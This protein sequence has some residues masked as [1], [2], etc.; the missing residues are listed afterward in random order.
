MTDTIQHLGRPSDREDPRVLGE[1]I[2][3]AAALVADPQ[4]P[5]VD[6]EWL[7]ESQRQPQALAEAL[8]AW[9]G[10]SGVPCKSVPGE[11][12]DLY[13]DWVVRHLRR[14]RTAFRWYDHLHER[15]DGWSSLSYDELDQR[16]AVR[17]AT[18]TSQGVV[19]GAV[20]CVMLPF[21]VEAVVSLL[22]ALRVGACVSL[23][24][25][26]GPAYVARRL[27]ALAPQHVASEPFYAPWL[28]AQAKLLLPPDGLEAIVGAVSH[29]YA[30]TD[31]C[32]LLFSPL[33]RPPELPVPLPASQAQLGAL[34]DGTLTLALRAGDCLAA[35]GLHREQHQP[36]L[37]FASLAAGAAF[38]HVPAD[39]ARRDPTLLD[40]FGLRTLGLDVATCEAILR[41]RGGPAH[42]WQHVFRNPEEPT[43]WQ[44]WRELVETR[45]LEETAMSNVVIEAASGGALLSSPRRTGKQQLAALMDVLPAAGQPWALLDFTR[46]GQ[47]SVADAGVFAPLGGEPGKEAPVEP[48]HIALGRRRDA[49]LYGGTIEP[50][51][52]GRVYPAEEV[53]AALEDC[54]F[55]HGASVVGVPAGGATL[56]WRFVLLGF[57]GHE[58]EARFAA[59][60]QARCDELQRM[61]ATRLGEALRPDA[62][63]LFPLLPRAPAG[64][65]DH[66]WCQLQYTSGTLFAKARTPVFRRITELRQLA[67]STT[68]T[69]STT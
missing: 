9:L 30:A 38:V 65:V 59:L 56:A 11:R 58:P 24:E 20:V 57:C 60:R 47:R 33:R 69:T 18:W 2:A 46:T 16:C 62:I 54:P 44:A 45:G 48:L 19:P 21:G 51:R 15:D 43:D 63:E 10:G 22:T 7:E 37:L 13:H 25:P 26:H 8:Q 6:G 23:L 41:V 39:A 5:A 52:S 3:A 28:G 14:G 49:Y 29:T 36:A 31:P 34:R 1:S 4:R 42:R 61:L 17:A 27:Q 32:A 35:P 12:Y 66:A 55:L 64:V 50:R 68:S 40:A 67:T 53:L